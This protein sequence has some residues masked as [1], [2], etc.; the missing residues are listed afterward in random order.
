MN[1]NQKKIL[2]KNSE[3]HVNIRQQAPRSPINVVLAQTTIASTIIPTTPPIP[4]QRPQIVFSSEVY[5]RPVLSLPPVI[6]M[7]GGEPIGRKCFSSDGRIA[8]NS[9]ESMHSSMPSS[10]IVEMPPSPAP[11]TLMYVEF[12]DDEVDVDVRIVDVHNIV[13]V[14]IDSILLFFCFIIF[15]C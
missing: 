14:R 1:L 12:P 11:S 5:H 6:L 7:G 10:P 3:S 8:Y 13:E 9:Y 15:F 2:F 4:Q